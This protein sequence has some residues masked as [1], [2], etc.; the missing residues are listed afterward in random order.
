MVEIVVGLLIIG[1][2]IQL[3]KKMPHIH[4]LI[5]DRNENKK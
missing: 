1:L 2:T 4:D 3:I 5:K